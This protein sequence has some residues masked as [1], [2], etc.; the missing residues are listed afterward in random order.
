MLPPLSQVSYEASSP[1]LSQKRA[2]PSFLRTIPSDRMQVEALVKL[3]QL[4]KWSWVAAVGSSNT[5][6][7]QGLQ[8]LQ[9]AATVAGLCIAYQGVIP[10]YK[11]SPELVSIV[12]A[13]KECTAN[14]VVVFAN[15]QSALLF[16]MEVV[17]QNLTGKVWLGTEDWSL[18]SETWQVA[19]IQAIGTVLGVSV[20][21][22]NLPGMKAFEATFADL[23][24]TSAHLPQ[25]GCSAP[26]CRH[27][28]EKCSQL[29]TQLHSPDPLLKPSPY[30]TQ[31]G[32]NVYTAVYALAH[33]LH[34]L[35]AC[36]SGVCR[37]DI[38]YP[39]Q[40]GLC[41]WALLFLMPTTST[42]SAF[43][44]LRGLCCSADCRFGSSG[45]GSWYSV[46]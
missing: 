3:L 36:Q 12:Q 27:C 5:Y 40:V 37:K 41:L 34:Q 19:G 31:G 1:L 42:S 21:Q 13:L 26:F 38:V 8:M 22:G 35:L 4:F 18:A 6:G 28:R 2:Y 43:K 39:W 10:A 33:G 9:D 7:R 20:K 29:C 14:V 23:D 16:F 15:K 11:G 24:N 32:F 44:T 45:T 30:D 46:A 25:D 17:W